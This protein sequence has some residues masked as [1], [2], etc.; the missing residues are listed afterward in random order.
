[1][2]VDVFSGIE[3]AMYLAFEMSI[4]GA[5]YACTMGI[6]KANRIYV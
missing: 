1:M 2:R 3:F 4:I 6:E 5:A